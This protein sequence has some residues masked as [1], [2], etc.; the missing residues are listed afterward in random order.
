MPLC[1]RPLAPPPIQ[2]P[3]PPYRL[4]YQLF[5]PKRKP[6]YRAQTVIEPRFVVPGIT[7]DQDGC[8]VVGA[9]G[10]G[11]DL[12]GD[13]SSIFCCS[14]SL[15]KGAASE[16]HLSCSGGD[17]HRGHPDGETAFVVYSGLSVGGSAGGESQGS[18][19]D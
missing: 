14:L 2:S 15:G 4:Y 6:V 5:S 17:L 12:D 13:A 9:V 11:G 7:Q 8:F 16:H 19:E 18:D 3:A 1:T 10:N